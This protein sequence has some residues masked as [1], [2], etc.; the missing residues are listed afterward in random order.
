MLDA[1]DYAQ[2]TPLDHAMAMRR[3]NIAHMLT[4]GGAVGYSA[5]QSTLAARVL[6]K[7]RRCLERKGEY[8]SREGQ[9]IVLPFRA[10]VRVIVWRRMRVAPRRFAQIANLKKEWDGLRSIMKPGSLMQ[11]A[12]DVLAAPIQVHHPLLLDPPSM[13]RAKE[14][15]KVVPKPVS[16]AIMSLVVM[17]D[18]FHMA[19]AGQ[20]TFVGRRYS[21]R[22]GAR[23]QGRYISLES[24]CARVGATRVSSW[25][26]EQVKRLDRQ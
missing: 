1:E 8:F 14:A 12:P 18:V 2:R 15:H 21:R 24:E 16:L 6:P 13:V 20:M 26:G 19:Y 23:C 25:G 4:R 9:Q 3:E 7:L 11:R 10:A 22:S 17:W 5:R